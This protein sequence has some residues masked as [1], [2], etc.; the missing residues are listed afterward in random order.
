MTNSLDEKIICDSGVKINLRK[1][2]L[3]THW[4]RSK[5]NRTLDKEEKGGGEEGKERVDMCWSSVF[6]GGREDN[7]QSSET[8]YELL[9]D[10]KQ[11]RV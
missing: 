9:P 11:K 3:I 7:V 8:S 2:W 1:F 10:R 6:F 5:L 4:Y